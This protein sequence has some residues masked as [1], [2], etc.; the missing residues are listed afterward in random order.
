M[1]TVNSR[2]LLDTLLS[3][4]ERDLRTRFPTISLRTREDE[5]GYLV[6]D[7]REGEDPWGVLGGWD[8]E[9]DD[10]PT[11]EDGER[12]LVGIAVEIADNLWPDELTDPWPLCPDHRSHPLHP[13]LTRGRAAWTC[14]RDA[15]VAI[16]IG[17]LESA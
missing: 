17:S 1:C 16:T 7:V 3:R 15:S 14:L 5:D 10:E 11:L 9:A 8:L 2:E 13:R 6:C 4:L 12:G